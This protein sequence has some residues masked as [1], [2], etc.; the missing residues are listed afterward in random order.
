LAI[1]R[2]SPTLAILTTGLLIGLAGCAPS[3][4]ARLVTSPQ[5]QP[6]VEA[7]GAAAV[8]RNW[9]QHPAILSTTSAGDILAVGDV[10]GDYDRLVALLQATGVIAKIP[11][12]PAK[13]EWTAGRATLVFPGDMIDKGPKCLEVLTVIQALQAAAAAKGGKVIAMMG[14]HEAEFLADPKADKVDDF[15]DELKAAGIA[16]KDVAAGRHPLGAFMRSLPLGVKVN[17]WFFCHA[18]NTAGKTIR[19]LESEIQAGVEARGFGDEAVL[20]DNSLLE[21]RLEPQP[22]WE[23][24]KAAPAAVLARNAKAL[25]VAHVVMGHQPGAVTFADGTSRQKGEIFQKYGLIF[26]IDGGMSQGVGYSR[27]SLL[28][29]AGP[30][31]TTATVH[32]ADRSTKPLWSR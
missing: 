21:S 8:P 20:G 11:A 14:N 24:E 23:R 5:G 9:R 27:G 28:R 15:K 29:I 19:Q 13:V 2:R 22:W 4:Y 6:T 12:S 16:P 7:A 17:D 3:L 25:G 32:F 1:P 18:G 10:H 30:L 26:L 31:F